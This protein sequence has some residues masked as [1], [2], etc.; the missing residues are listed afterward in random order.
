M[1]VLTLIL[2]AASLLAGCSGDGDSPEDAAAAGTGSGPPA[3]SPSASGSPS[4][5]APSAGASADSTSTATPDGTSSAT[6]AATAPATVAPVSAPGPL[7]TVAFPGSPTF[8]RPV[9][10]FRYESGIAVADQGGVVRLVREGGAPVTLLDIGDR[11][12]RDGNEEGLLS[13][14]LDPAFEV[15][16]WLW[17]YYSAASPRRTVLSRFEVLGNGPTFDPNSEVTVLE[18][19]QP[20]PN[21]NGGAIRFGPDDMLYLG[22]GDG[23][24]GGDPQGN[25]QNLTTILGKIIRLD[26]RT[27]TANTP[28]AIPSDNPY[29]RSGGGLRSEIFALGLRNPWRMSFDPATGDLWVADVGQGEVEEVGIAAAGA[30]LGWAVMEGDRCY[31]ATTCQ[32]AGLVLPLAVYDHSGGRCSVSGGVVARGV[33]ATNVEGAYLYADF[34]SGELWALPTEGGDPETVATGLGSVSSI[35]Q[36]GDRLFVLA[37]GSPLLE[38]RNGN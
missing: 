15:N 30:N 21:H 26:V 22:L 33:S 29:A 8:D 20:Y 25:G 6:A 7:R 17:A 24:S 1:R 16:G 27:S 19:A 13:I 38:L 34:C 3:A 2:L 11:V 9:D 14:A 5:P 12:S 31:D 10:A 32:T 23:G 28:Y 35:V 18:Q 4:A 36:V 37:F